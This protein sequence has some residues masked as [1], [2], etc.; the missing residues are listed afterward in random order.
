MPVRCYCRITIRTIDRSQTR[1]THA[2]PTDAASACVHRCC[3]CYC[4]Y[5]CCCVRSRRRVRRQRVR[6]VTTRPAAGRHDEGVARRRTRQQLMQ[7]L[8]RRRTS[9]EIQSDGADIRRWG[10]EWGRERR[11][12]TFTHAAS[13]TSLSSRWLDGNH[14]LCCALDD[15]DDEAD[16]RWCKAR[17]PSALRLSAETGGV[18]EPRA[19]VASA[20]VASGLTVEGQPA[21][22]AATNGTA[23]PQSARLGCVRSR[24][25]RTLFNRGRNRGRVVNALYR[26]RGPS[27]VN[28][29]MST[30]SRTL[31]CDN[32][33]CAFASLLPFTTRRIACT[34]CALYVTSIL[35]ITVVSCVSTA[36]R[37]EVTFKTEIVQLSLGKTVQY[38]NYQ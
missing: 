31:R 23:W 29:V 32:R 27:I 5:W 15:E 22:R 33:A 9:T 36:E 4:C 38:R 25:R 17:S 26:P 20:T 35:S 6:H 21:E 16:F 10:W 14:V 37:I 34:R 2:R 8:M 28:A 11:L 24:R 7:P 30:Y 1:L 19:D 13:A 18:R 3:S 12:G